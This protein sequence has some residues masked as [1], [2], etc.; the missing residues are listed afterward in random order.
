[1]VRLYGVHHAV[2]ISYG[3]LIPKSRKLPVTPSSEF[4]TDLD[5]LPRRSRIGLECF[6]DQD[7]QDIKKH[8]ELRGVEADFWGFP[9]YDDND[10]LYWGSIVEFLRKNGH[11][12][13]F[14][15]D[16]E[17][18]KRYNEATIELGK[19]KEEELFH[20]DGE[21]DYHYHGKLCR[22]NERYH[23]AEIYWRKI[24]EID[25]DIKLLEAIK[26]NGVKAVIVGRGHGDYWIANSNLIEDKFSITFEDYS[27]DTIRKGVLNKD[28]TSA[29]TVFTRN[30]VPDPK[31][32]FERESLERTLRLIEQGRIILDRV[33][34]YIG[35]W[36]V[37]FPSKGYF[38]MFVERDGDERI[39]GKIEDSLGTATFE[40]VI[41]PT[42][43]NFVKQYIVSEETAVQEP[44]E[45]R[46]KRKGNHLYGHFFI[47]EY[48]GDAFY[49]TPSSS[50]TNPVNMSLRWDRL[51]AIER[52]KK[53]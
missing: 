41:T 49:M 1:M 47:N 13:V 32:V 23:K 10:R 25:R 7:W 48:L 8:L 26:S 11:E 18:W 36:D 4:L 39:S 33:P 42:D 5:S 19:C 37:Y 24:H 31:L 46:A 30:A 35:I 14:L 21:S 12:P 52:G 27:T 53:Q 3:F 34:D 28:S 44:V 2:N 45:Y 38:E 51:Q 20:E 17:T 9:H 40:G 6:D 43:F 15:E 29:Q 16:K 50:Q 22:Y